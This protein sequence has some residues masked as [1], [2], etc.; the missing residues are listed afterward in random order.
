MQ[1]S[2]KLSKH[3]ISFATLAQ[4]FGYDR[5][6]IIPDIVSKFLPSCAPP[7]EVVVLCDRTLSRRPFLGQVVDLDLLLC[8]GFNSEEPY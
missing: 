1:I 7:S 6:R 8:I 3:R 2:K 4:N 5:F